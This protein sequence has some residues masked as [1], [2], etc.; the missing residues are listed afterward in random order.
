MVLRLWYECKELHSFSFP[1][2]VHASKLIVG[3]AHPLFLLFVGIATAESAILS[4][5]FV[6][7]GT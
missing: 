5:L 2:I 6:V 3:P 1:R 7:W 4:P